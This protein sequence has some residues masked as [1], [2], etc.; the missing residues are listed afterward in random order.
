MFGR[1]KENKCKRLRTGLARL[2]ARHISPEKGWMASHIANCPRCQ[3][4]MSR[5]GRVDLAFML[6]KSQ[7]HKLDLFKRANSQ[8]IGVLK[9]SLRDAPKA[10]KLK[11]FQPEPVI[12]RNQIRYISAIVNA[13]ACIAIIVLLKV[14]V[15]SSMDNYHEQGKEAVQHYYAKHLGDELADD[16]FNA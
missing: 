5:I 6:I 12:S 11:D 10:V 14:G 13:A 1:K 3:Q 8:A 2:L 4:R 16:I 7:V 9:H 15:F